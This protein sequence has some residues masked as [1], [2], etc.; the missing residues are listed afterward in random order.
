MDKLFEKVFHLCEQILDIDRSILKYKNRTKHKSMQLFEAYTTV[1]QKIVKAMNGFGLALIGGT[2]LD[3]YCRTYGVKMSRNRSKND[4][5]FIA[6]AHKKIEPA[7]DWL[8][9]NGFEL[10]TDTKGYSIHLEMPDHSVEVDILVDYSKEFFDHFQ[11]IRGIATMSP[12]WLFTSKFQRYVNTTDSKRKATDEKDL[13]NWLEI[14]NKLN[15]VDRLEE[16][17]S[18]SYFSSV[19]EKKLNMLIDKYNATHSK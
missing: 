9:Q 11:V 2:A 19:E 3:V 6:P 18:K 4:L 14:I 7:I 5:D 8:K 10:K 13:L 16:L 15:M 12:S 17:L 1:D